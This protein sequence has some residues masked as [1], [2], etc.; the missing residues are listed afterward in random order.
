MTSSNSG[1]TSACFVRASQSYILNSGASPCT[2]HRPHILSYTSLFVVANNSILRLQK[3]SI[4]WRSARD[5]GCIFCSNSSPP[6]GLLGHSQSDETDVVPVTR[7]LW[8][9]AKCET[10]RIALDNSYEIVSF[11]SSR[12]RSLFKPKL[13]SGP[14][15]NQ[16][17][18]LL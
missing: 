6:P 2:S 18:T 14:A 11:G 13:R 12:Q 16:F 1:R 10:D 15:N 9:Q 17:S 5:A 8:I 4:F 7:A 3:D